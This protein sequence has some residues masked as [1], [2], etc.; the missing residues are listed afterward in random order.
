VEGYLALAEDGEPAVYQCP[1]KPD[2]SMKRNY[3]QTVLKGVDHELVEGICD[4]P[5]EYQNLRV[6]G[7]RADTPAKS[8]D[9]LL[10]AEREG[11]YD[12]EYTFLARIA[13][14]RIL[15]DET[16]TEF[17]D[18][19]GWGEGLDSTFPHVMFLDTIHEAD[20]NRETL[21]ELLGFS[22]WPND[23]YSRINFDR[24]GAQY[25]NEYDS[26]EAFVDEIKGQQIYP[27]NKRYYWLNTW[28]EDFQEP[29][30]EIFC[31][32]VNKRGGNRNNRQGFNNAMPGDEVIIYHGNPVKQV[33]GRGYVL[34]GLHTEY[35]ES[36][37]EVVEGITV[38]WDES[39]D[40]PSW[41]KI[42]SDPQ[43]ADCDVVTSNNNYYVASITGT[44]YERFLELAEISTYSDYAD[45]LAVTADDISVEK[46]QL[47]Y[48]ASEWDR[49]KARI[50]QALNAG[51]HVLLF[52]PPGTGKTKLA[53][54][55]CTASV[56]KDGY[57]L[58]TASA[59]WSTFDTV[60]GY[61]TTSENRLVFEPGVV[62][63]RFHA[64]NE[65]TP[66]NE[67]LV[68]DELNRA[69]IDKAFG[70]LFSAL[71]GE[72]VTLPFDDSDGEPIQI[73]DNSRD[74]E[75]IGPNRYYIPEDWRMLAT[76]NTLDKTSL[77]EMSYAF[78]RR[79]AF[80][81][82]GIPDLPEPQDDDESELVSLIE[83][84][85][86]VWVADDS[87]P[88]APAHYEPIGQIW[89]AVN[90]ERAIGPA[91]VED[92][93]EHV[94]AGESQET[95]DYVSPIIM[96][97][98]PQ[99]EGLRRDELERLIERLDAIVDDGT[100]ELWRVARDFFQVDLQPG[101]GE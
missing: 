45:E 2:G 23:P 81:P 36:R 9:Y 48:P 28:Q 15:N 98:F 21:W 63:D 27:R 47:H 95:A 33:V 87:V 29:G 19:V 100:G 67:W 65:G 91:I 79:W 60:G 58:V 31:T 77:Y 72:S 99:L 5:I 86:M 62:L 89:R 24:D 82:V 20:V 39:I 57:E 41:D 80:I 75:E 34:E 90:E 16:A 85:V 38:A 71:T 12:G 44:E 64:D 11:R 22:A 18:A 74:N 68:I 32:A 25:Y 76:I 94:A 37:D 66:A 53:R 97:V 10:F 26:I 93:Y 84:Y 61:R 51:N 83:S 14:A 43:L 49:I 56:G 54:Q 42:K 78:M 92:I 101:D 69:D 6:W 1:I 50:K 70:S 8:G 30:G 40:G 35:S 17:T 96:Y 3:G 46:G 7:N 88:E 52:G 55:V 59:D 73:L 4:I 13:D